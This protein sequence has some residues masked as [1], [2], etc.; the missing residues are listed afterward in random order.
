[1]KF[2]H[3]LT[4]DVHQAGKSGCAA[5]FR[6]WFAPLPVVLAGGTITYVFSDVL[7]AP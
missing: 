6:A 2:K 3:F 4:T 1:V 5:P 7:P